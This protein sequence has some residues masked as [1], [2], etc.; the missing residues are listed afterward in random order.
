MN[1]QQKLALVVLALFSI[2]AQPCSAAGF[3]VAS[4]FSD[5]AVLQRGEPVPVWGWAD[6][7]AT[8]AVEFTGQKKSTVADTNGRWQVKLDA[9]QALNTGQKMVVVC[10]D[11]SKTINDVVVGE[12]WFC[13]GQS[14]MTV[15]LG[16]LVESPVKEK[17]YQPI[18]DYIN[19]EIETASDPLLRQF[20]VGIGT[21]PF[22]ELDRGKG[23]WKASSSPADTSRFTGTGYFFG[24]E[25]RAKL[26]V[27]VGLIKCDY[28]G[29]L[30]RPWIPESGYRHFPALWAKVE[31]ERQTLKQKIEAYDPVE[32]RNKYE[33]T[34]KKWEAEGKKGRKPFKFGDP[35]KGPQ[36]HCTLFNGMVHPVIPYGIKG[37]IWYQGE[38]NSG[39]R[40]AEYAVLFEA[41]VRGWRES[42]GKP[43]L[44]FYMAQLA[45]FGK[46][47]E[48]RQWLT[49]AQRLAINYVPH[50]GLAVLN[51][52]GETKDVHP[53]NKIDVGKRLALWALEHD[54][55]VDPPAH[56]GP[57]YSSHQSKGDHIVVT[58]DHAGSGLMLGRKELLDD[59]KQVDEPLPHFEICGVLG[60]WQRAQAEIIGNN[61]VK[62]WSK[63]VFR[64]HWVRYAW[65]ADL[66]GTMLYNK[67]GLPTSI[68]TTA[69]N[70]MDVTL[71][72]VDEGT[73]VQNLKET[74]GVTAVRGTTTK[75][76]GLPENVA[77][78]ARVTASSVFQDQSAE[79]AID[80]DPQ[81][82]WASAK[83]GKN[84]AMMIRLGQ[85]HRI[86][87]I[88]YQSR[89]GVFER[90]QS[91]K[92]ASGEGGLQVCYLQGAKLQTEFQYFNIDD[93]ETD[94]VRWSVLDTRFGSNTG[95]MEI[96][97]YG[98]P[99]EQE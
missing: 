54:Y 70:F 77:L 15:W 80:G 89:N 50:T 99:V 8:V 98:V 49:E 13:S 5:G 1:Q 46:E 67:E 51:D 36:N 66:D 91:F 83:D 85:N 44:P 73:L 60:D 93:V 2:L 95:A 55:K 17:R 82:G 63:G 45:S 48:G 69:P 18:V 41:M 78:K 21:S 64:P 68:F 14:N 26:G 58:F 38:S 37:V 35:A 56:C 42:W 47:G 39:N 7:G 87:H 12:V 24:K 25:L 57:L 6:P 11:E 90:V 71:R 9:M 72:S 88:G 40:A 28:G 84:A 10:G 29:T 94:V 53:K 31:K 74:Y 96:A 20:Q 23:S 76:Q 79:N 61:S 33:A 34:L 32:S 19:K 59:A 30:I 4:I 27:P 62:V 97:V 81:T 52:V 75:P 22:E 92:V 65:Q 16:F 3:S 43:H 86:T